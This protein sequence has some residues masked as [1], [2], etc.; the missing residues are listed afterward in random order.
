[1]TQS[2]SGTGIA[3]TGWREDVDVNWFNL[4]LVGWVIVIIAVAIA[5]YMM[6]A[7]T[8]WIAIGA[9]LM[10]GVG[11]ISAVARSKPQV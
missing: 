6:H 7:P 8:I 9:L 5:A 2:Q 1:M 10:L 3:E 4:A 11:I